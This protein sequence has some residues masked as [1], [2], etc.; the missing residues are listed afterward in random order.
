MP[1]VRTTKGSANAKPPL[2]K[3]QAVAHASA[4]PV[5]RHPTHV[6]LAHASL[7]HEVFHETTNRVIIECRHNRRVHTKTAP[8]SA[9][10]VVFASTFPRSKLTRS[11]YTI[12]TGIESEHDFPEAHQ[13]PYA[14][15]FR[16]DF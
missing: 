6:F 1:A 7:Q 14:F 16:P 8:E 4:N 15:V 3:I 12:V 13:V 11:R 10:Y 2:G 5:I 9:G